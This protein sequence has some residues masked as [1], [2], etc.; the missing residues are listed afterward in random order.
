MTTDIKTKLGRKPVG[1][2][3]MT[4]AERK[5]KSRLDKQIA[6]AVVAES[7]VAAKSPVTH[8]PRKPKHKVGSVS[9]HVAAMVAAA[10]DIPSPPTYM[11]LSDAAWLFW[12]AII[13]TRASSDWGDIELVLAAQLAECQAQMESEREILKGESS[14]ETNAF[15]VS[16]PNP[17][18]AVIQTYC[19]RQLALMRSLR[20]G[21]KPAGE[22]RDFAGAARMESQARKARS[23]V[24]DEDDLLA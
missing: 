18:I 12:P 20:M 7:I 22:P 15:G 4:A 19:T 10:D 5:R 3:P 2:K 9:A 13:A 17:R 8:T 11:P 23:S 24:E 6:A 14:V 16:K 1:D 21:G